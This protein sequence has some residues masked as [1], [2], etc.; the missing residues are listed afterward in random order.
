MTAHPP[1]TVG[2]LSGDLTRY[3]WAMVSLRELRVPDGA[4]LAWVTGDWVSTA[5]NRI[6]ASMR[7][8][9]EWVCI[10]T[11][12]NPVPADMLLRL[13]DHQVPLVAPLVCLRIPPYRP[14]LFHDATDGGF[15]PYF[16]EELDGQQG[17][18]PVDSFGG[19]GVVIRREVLEAVG[20]PFFENMPWPH[21]R[22]EPHEDLYTFRKCRQAG[23]QPLVD[24]DLC[25]GHC[26]PAIVTPD[27]D[28]VGQHWG[29]H[30]WSH[31]S[32]GVLRPQTMGTVAPDAPEPM[33]A[34]R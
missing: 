20:M 19:P 12:D 26:I 6:I 8:Q 2:I 22:Q 18:Y 25:I 10:L 24:L 34:R 23:F 30:V 29:V 7:P 4:Q 17:L 11:D 3:A 16:W 13:L 14:A 9:D 33:P 32:L 5:V 15:L 31:T 27:Y 21:G 28:P 1:G